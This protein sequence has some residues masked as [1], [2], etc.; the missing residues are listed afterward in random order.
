MAL[1][2]HQR[3][4]EQNA[5]GA[6]GADDEVLESRLAGVGVPGAEGRQAHGRKGHDLQH[7]VDVEEVAGEDYA[8]DAAGQHEVEREIAAARVVLLY[9]AE[10]VEAGA[11]HR[12][13]DEQAEEQAQ[14]V[15]LYGDAYG[16]AAHGLPVAH[17]VD[18]R[19]AAYHDGLYKQRQKR[20]RRQD[21]HAGYDVAQLLALARERHEKGAHEQHHDGEH[22]E[23]HI[24]I[25]CHPCSLLISR[26][27]RVPYSL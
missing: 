2:I 6:Y 19:L 15:H 7:Y 16:V 17:P 14:R 13:G 26:A 24:D 4:A 22:G 1:G 25:V 12:Y 21:G 3:R 18:Y 5:A 9:V 10:G 8:H 27:S 23:M 11:G 20:Q